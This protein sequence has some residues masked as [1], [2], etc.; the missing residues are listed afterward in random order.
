MSVVLCR[1]ADPQ[2]ARRRRRGTVGTGVSLQGHPI[3]AALQLEPRQAS[4]VGALFFLGR[5]AHARRMPRY[6][7][8]VVYPDLTE[9]ADSRGTL[10]QNDAAAIRIAARV[11]ND[12]SADRGNPIV[13]VKNE[14]GEVVYRYPTN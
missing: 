10:L 6:F 8:S 2:L 12:F 5:G 4:P 7:F 13:I 14:A 1:H 3:V 11:F 9:L